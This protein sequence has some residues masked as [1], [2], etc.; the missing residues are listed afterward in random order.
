MI[1]INLNT[2]HTHRAQSYQKNLHK[3]LYG[4]TH[5]HTH[6]YAFIYMYIPGMKACTKLKTSTAKCKACGASHMVF[7]LQL[8]PSRDEVSSVPQW[9]WRQERNVCITVTISITVILIM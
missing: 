1:H 5:T 8:V 4:N 2:I 7:H 6:M 3:V 9:E